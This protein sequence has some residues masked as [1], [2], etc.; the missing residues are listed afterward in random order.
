MTPFLVRR[1]TCADLV[2]EASLVPGRF[3][4]SHSPA[5]MWEA[6]RAILERPSARGCSAISDDVNDKSGL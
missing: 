1:R 4:V 3:M 5:T 6:R 2:G